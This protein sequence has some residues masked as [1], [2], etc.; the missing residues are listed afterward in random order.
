[1]LWKEVQITTTLEAEE[2]V[3]N[4]FYD[5]GADGVAIQTLQDVLL[6]QQDPK[7]NF[8]DEALLGNRS[9]CFDCAGL[10]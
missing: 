1:M 3:V 8:I 9:Q 7:V 2:A 5:A 10:F 6:I 4:A